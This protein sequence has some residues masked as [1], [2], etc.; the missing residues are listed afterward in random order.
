MKKLFITLGLVASTAIFAQTQTEGAPFK[1]PNFYFSAK[2]LY[3]KEFLDLT[4]KILEKDITTQ[5]LYNNFDGAM[6]TLQNT[7]RK[8][9]VSDEKQEQIIR[10]IESYQNKKVSD[11][12]NDVDFPI[13]SVA[14]VN[15]SGSFLKSIVINRILE[16]FLPEKKAKEIEEE[17]AINAFNADNANKFLEEQFCSFHTLRVIDSKYK[18]MSE[19]ILNHFNNKTGINRVIS[20]PD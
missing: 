4:I 12:N 1:C 9:D 16:E 6:K 3:K 15:S 5:S 20:K 18:N 8:Y 10:K 7:L 14:V 19:Y 13:I 2:H 11:L 17:L